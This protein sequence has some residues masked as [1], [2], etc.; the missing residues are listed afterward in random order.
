VVVPLV[1]VVEGGEVMA[2]RPLQR[3]LVKVSFLLLIFCICY[4]LGIIILYA[5]AWMPRMGPVMK[6]GL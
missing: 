2:L 5:V 1:D 3:R 6:V 4:G